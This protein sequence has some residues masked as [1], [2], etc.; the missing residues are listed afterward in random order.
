VLDSASVTP[1]WGPAPLQVG[2]D[3][4][5]VYDPDGDALTLG[6]DFGDG[7]APTATPQT[8]HTYAANG[9]YQAVL[10]VEDDGTPALG[11]QTRSFRIAVTDNTPPDASNAAVAPLAGP[12]PLTVALDAAGCGDPDGDNLTFFWDIALDMVTSQTFDTARAA[13]TFDQPGSYEITLTLTDD[14]TPPLEVTRTFVV[15]AQAVTAPGQAVVGKG[16][17]CA[18]AGVEGADAATVLLLGA[19]AWR[20]RRPRISF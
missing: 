17:A 18:G 15:E 8:Q 16:C 11:P 9:E 3:A 5:G 14:G 13:Y 12:V 6:W 2:F 19:L 20:R 10:T 4:S 1:L 7:S